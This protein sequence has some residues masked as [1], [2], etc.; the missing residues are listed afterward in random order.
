[1]EYS[2]RKF[3]GIISSLVVTTPLLWLAKSKFL[4]NPKN[5]I[6]GRMLGANYKRGHNLLKMLFSRPKECNKTTT[7]IIGGGVS[8]ISTAMTLYQNGQKDFVLLELEDSIGGNSR[9]DE[10]ASGRFPLGAHYLP[11]PSPDNKELI[12]L[13]IDLGLITHFNKDGLPYYHEQHLC[14]TPDERLFING[15][16]QEGLIPT[17]GVPEND[18]HQIQEFLNLMNH[19]KLLK[20]SDNKY[21]FDIPVDQSSSDNDFR[22]LDNI[23]MLNF[24]K[25]H[26]FTSSYLQWYVEYCCKDDYGCYLNEIS[27]WAGIHYFASRRGLAANAGPDHVLTWPEGNCWLVNKMATQFQSNIQT[28]CM[29]FKITQTSDSSYW[30][31]YIDYKNKGMVKRYEAQKVVFCGPQFV[32]KHIDTNIHTLKKRDFSQFEYSSWVTGNAEVITK[33]LIER[34]GS[35]LSWENII[36]KSNSL[37]YVNASNQFLSRTQASIN[38]PWYYLAPSSDSRKQILNS[39]Y[40]HWSKLLINDFEKVYSNFENSLISVDIS[41]WGHAMIKPKVG[42]IWSENR[43]SASKSIDNNLYFAHTDLSGIS[44]F[45]EGFLR[46]RSVALQLITSLKNE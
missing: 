26:H 3:I 14:H 20:G 16:W 39:T 12:N 23:T 8:G 28:G 15:Y 41:V 37:G 30:V 32:L 40:E 46:G 25:Q 9:S 13:L 24:M 7:L 27:A 6:K 44:I 34:K 19:Y 2:R 1:M 10:N 33:N 45:E 18:K 5:K 42:F 35:P 4:E 43:L 11:V 21:A 31:D 29:V 17:F 38:L 36:Y 22:K